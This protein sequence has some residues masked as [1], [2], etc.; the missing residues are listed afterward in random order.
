VPALT[1]GTDKSTSTTF[2][3]STLGSY[4]I[5]LPAESGTVVVDAGEGA[6]NGTA[7]TVTTTTQGTGTGPASPQ[8]IV[9]YMKVIGA[10]G[11]TYYIPLM[12]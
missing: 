4:S 8:T 10:D 2:S 7:S 6:G 5:S 12:Q 3:A 11:N 9:K 1:L